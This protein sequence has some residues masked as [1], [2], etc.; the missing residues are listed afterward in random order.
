MSIAT[1]E[2]LATSSCLLFSDLTTWDI[3]EMSFANTL[4]ADGT[5]NADAGYYYVKEDNDKLIFNPCKY[6][7]FGLTYT[8]SDSG[9]YNKWSSISDFDVE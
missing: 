3:R 6:L 8:E 7:N 1:A 4:N 2:E 9:E 5:T